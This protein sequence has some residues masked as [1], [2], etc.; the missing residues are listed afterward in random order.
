MPRRSAR[1]ASGSASCAASGP[2][3]RPRERVVAV[4]RR[5]R[6]RARRRASATVSAAESVVGA[7]DSRLEVDLDAVRRE[8]P[9]DDG[10]G[11]TLPAGL[12]APPGAVEQIGEQRDRL[13]T[14]EQRRPH[15]APARP[16]CR[17]DRAPARSARARPE[18]PD[19]RGRRCKRGARVP[20][21]RPAARARARASRARRAPKRSARAARRQRRARAASPRAHPP[22]RPSSSRAYA[23]RAYDARLGRSETIRSNAANACV[24]PAELDSAS[25]I[26][27][28]GR[29]EPGSRRCARR[30]YASAS[31]TRAG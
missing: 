5:S 28:Y 24:V 30:P 14:S 6:C 31:G 10:D 18:R 2:G 26:T 16:R 7:V 19:T 22:G 15:A 3:K 13:R 11:R 20:R 21:A 1:S 4:D 17:G 25:P 9:V 12:G 23:T 27:P 8:Q 29:A